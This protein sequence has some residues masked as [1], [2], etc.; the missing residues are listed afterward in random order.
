MSG[1]KFS[2]RVS[3]FI[4]LFLA[5]GPALAQ[6]M[7]GE[8]LSRDRIV[9]AGVKTQIWTAWA[10]TPDCE[11]VR[12]FNVQVVRLPRHGA[13]A[14]EKVQEVI[15]PRWLGHSVPPQRL[16]IVR[17]CMGAPVT[18]IGVFYT[19]NASHPGDD[20]LSI[21]ITNASQTRQRALEIGI[22]V[23]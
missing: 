5:S 19:A 4:C 12:G 23:R 8:A 6:R 17:R 21:I 20:S 13:V 18:T 7:Q 11:V 14:L 3:A 15:T 9:R 22:R 16:A 2:A 10:L 1:W